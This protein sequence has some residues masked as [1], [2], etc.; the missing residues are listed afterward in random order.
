MAKKSE[1]PV[2]ETLSSDKANLGEFIAVFREAIKGN[3]QAIV[4]ANDML[5]GLQILYDNY[6]DG[7]EKVVG[8]SLSPFV[9]MNDMDDDEFGPS[10]KHSK[11]KR[12]VVNEYHL[13]I[14]LNNTNL[15]IW[16]ELKVPSNVELDFLGLLLIDIMGWDGDHLFQFLHNKM[17]YS[18]EETVETS[19]HDN[20]EPMSK[21]ALSDL[22]KE[23]GDRMMLEYDFG[24]SW[25]HD[26][27][28][29]DIRPYE[30]KEKPHIEYVKGHG[31]CP[32]DNCGGIGEYEHLLELLENLK[33]KKRLTKEEREELEWADMDK[34]YNPDEFNDGYAKYIAAEWDLNL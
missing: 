5:D 32:P 20:V 6:P 13:R 28:V 26:V 2:I 3:K 9:S 15:K 1:K 31:E 22:L 17:F 19:W 34:D 16:R 18:D 11:L 14:K 23:K 21:F 29:K 12:P 33:Q 30:K 25:K 4:V 8:S 10:Y 7:G 27:W 24:D